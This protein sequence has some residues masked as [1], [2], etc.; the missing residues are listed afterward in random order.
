MMGKRRKA[1]RPHWFA[2]YQ[3][4]CSTDAPRRKDILEYCGTHG[5]NRTELFKNYIAVKVSK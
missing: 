3:C 5:S 2:Q 1:Y 4:G